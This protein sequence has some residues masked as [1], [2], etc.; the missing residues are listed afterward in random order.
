MHEAVLLPHVG[1]TRRSVCCEFS[2]PSD[3]GGS[4]RHAKVRRADP[5]DAFTATALK[6]LRET[7]SDTR[8][9]LRTKVRDRRPH[10]PKSPC[11]AHRELGRRAGPRS[12][13]AASKAGSLR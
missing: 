12:R 5:R 9:V 8:I 6:K 13:P 1:W 11:A 3:F 2:G 7:K 4:R 10:R